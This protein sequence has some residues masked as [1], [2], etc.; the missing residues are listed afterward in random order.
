MAFEQGML[1]GTVIT[2]VI[3]IVGIDVM[4]D[5][6]ATAGF[7]G[8]LATVTDNIP[9]LFAVGLLVAAVGWALFR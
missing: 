5:I 7:A 9:V 6:I 2:V 4:T 3:G 8:T 1:I